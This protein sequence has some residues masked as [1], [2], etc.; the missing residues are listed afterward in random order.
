[1]PQPFLSTG[2]VHLCGTYAK[3]KITILSDLI[4]DMAK[5]FY[6]MF[7]KYTEKRKK[8]L[9]LFQRKLVQYVYHSRCVT[10]VCLR[11]SAQGKCCVFCHFIHFICIFRQAVYS[12]TRMHACIVNHSVL[13]PYKPTYF[14]NKTIKA[15]NFVYCPL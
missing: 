7:T 11:L 9:L 15:L 3:Q 8:I 13:F 6:Y 10:R 1:M 4:S 12:S 2:T 14:K 5:H